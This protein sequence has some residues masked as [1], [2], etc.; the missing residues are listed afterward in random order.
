MKGKIDILNLEPISPIEIEDRQDVIMNRGDF[1]TDLGPTMHTEEDQD[2]E[3]SL[4]VG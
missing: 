3:E 2:M 4:E 1:K